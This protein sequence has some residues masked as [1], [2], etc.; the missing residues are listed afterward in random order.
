MAKA[1]WKFTGKTR[2]KAWI[3]KTRNRSISR[4][5]PATGVPLAEYPQPPFPALHQENM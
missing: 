5:S 4:P 1:G 3:G 2:K